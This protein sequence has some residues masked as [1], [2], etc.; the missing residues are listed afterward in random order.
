MARGDALVLATTTL[1]D[2]SVMSKRPLRP[3]RRSGTNSINAPLSIRRK[4]SLTKKFARMDSGVQANGLEQDRDRHLAATVD[5]EEQDV[6]LGSN[7]KS[8][9]EP[10]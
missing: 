7:S 8:S 6:A 5:A 4:L 2:L 3:C 9:Q 1:P 10:R